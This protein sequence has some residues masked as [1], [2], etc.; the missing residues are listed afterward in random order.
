MVF[1]N[2]MYTDNQVPFKIPLVYQQGVPSGLMILLAC[3]KCIA[4]VINQQKDVLKSSW[5]LTGTATKCI[6][7]I[8]KEQKHSKI[9]LVTVVPCRYEKRQTYSAA[10]LM[11]SFL[12]YISGLEVRSCIKLRSFQ[13]ITFFSITTKRGITEVEELSDLVEP[14]RKRI[15]MVF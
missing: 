12:H 13:A 9:C 7:T 11:F 14:V 5:S 8:V 3:T 4:T 1:D 10:Q 15:F 6:A 2:Y